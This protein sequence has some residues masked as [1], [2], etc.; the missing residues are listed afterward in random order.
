M[1]AWRR[2][3]VAWKWHFR[4]MGIGMGMGM[5]MVWAWHFNVSGAARDYTGTFV[6]KYYPS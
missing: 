5:G 4:E 3:G 1:A 6:Y 2:G